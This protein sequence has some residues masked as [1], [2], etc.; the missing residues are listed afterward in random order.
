MGALVTTSLVCL[1]LNRSHQG[2]SEQNGSPSSAIFYPVTVVRVLDFSLCYYSSD[3]APYLATYITIPRQILGVVL[4]ILAATKTLKQSIDMYK[5][6][7]HWESNK[8]MTLLARDGI[9]YFFLYVFFF[10][11]PSL[12]SNPAQPPAYLLS[13]AH[14]HKS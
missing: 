14:T 2:D 3:T 1:V 7:K 11:R 10:F 13:V 5:A 12:S 6:T 4:L 8:Y 9:L